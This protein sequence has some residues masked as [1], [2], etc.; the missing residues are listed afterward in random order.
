MKSYIVTCSSSFRDAVQTLATKK[1]VTASDLVTA[2]LVLNDHLGPDSVPDPGDAGRDDR[3]IIELK[4]GPRAGRYLRRKPR[5]QLRLSEGLSD[6]Y[7]RRA[8]ALL[9]A[10]DAGERALEEPDRPTNDR[11]EPVLSPLSA[12]SSSS[13]RQSE[14]SLDRAEIDNARQHAEEM[15]AL[16]SLM[17]FDPLPDGV[18]TVVDARYVL[19]LPPGMRL[20]RRIVKARFRML[21]QIYHPDKE[22]GDTTRMAQLIDAFRLMESHI[23]QREAAE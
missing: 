2:V 5:L 16:V 6:S 21:S 20:T 10:L 14:E 12:G 4:S 8:L 3:D 18:N 1:G 22:T 19:G 9:I 15:R 23:R 7:I 11:T 13:D 17:T